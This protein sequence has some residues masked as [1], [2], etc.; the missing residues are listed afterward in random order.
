[1]Q[2]N[3]TPGGTARR[4]ILLVSTRAHNPGDDFIRIGI[5]HLLRLLYPGAVLRTMHKHD[6][7]TMFAG[8]KQRARTPHRLLAP[9]LY[10]LYAALPGRGR[11]NY[12]ETADLVVFAG[13]PFIWRSSLRTLPFN[14]ANAEW[15]PFTWRR[16]FEDL[17]HQPVLNLSAG[18]SV[19]SQEQAD[20]LLA[21]P[22]VTGFLK[23]AVSRSA[24]TTARDNR[25]RKILGQLGFD[26]PVLPCASIL[27]ARGAQI[28]PRP[29]EY[30]VVNLMPSAAHS[31]RGQRG[32][33]AH[34][35]R[36][37][38]QVAADL[39]K[40]HQLLFVSHSA[41]EDAAAAAWFPQHRRVYSQDP[42]VLLKA[43][44]RARFGVCN[45]V[46]AGAAIASFGRPAI[47]IGGDSRVELIE[48]FGL[49][50]FDHR[51]LDA[52]T[53]IAAVHGIEADYEQYKRR[54]AC[55]IEEAERAYLAAI[56]PAG[57]LHPQP[58]PRV[59]GRDRLGLGQ[60]PCTSARSNG[61]DPWQVPAGG[62]AVARGA[63]RA[64]THHALDRCPAR[65]APVLRSARRPRA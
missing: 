11:E 13:T 52:A 41:D 23:Q 40:R 28:E 18:T 42:L 30:V 17:A 46:H 59:R 7:R 26:V 10:R 24:L 62:G 37:I 33:P 8:F 51:H 47:V 27:A 6:P 50:A 60:R 1:M 31:W 14:S 3:P 48:Q 45:R 20:A 55:C 56:D 9:H 2:P 53:L 39:E 35:R 12:L 57:C 65:S 38:E 64:A 36:V 54:L 43:Y 15:V 21:D 58:I 29:P 25:T 4:N 49:P 19:T 32:D 44:A 63:S 16:L 34:W 22:A 5:E 61:G